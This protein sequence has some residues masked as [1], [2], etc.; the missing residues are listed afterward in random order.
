MEACGS[1]SEGMS[2]ANV[3][4]LTQGRRENQAQLNALA[5]LN[6]D[7]PALCSIHANVPALSLARA[8]ARR[9][10]LL[11]P[12]RRHRGHKHLSRPLLA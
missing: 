2:Q 6:C 4:S 11:A 9:R 3:R 1:G 8:V 5:A 7:L 12:V 10:A